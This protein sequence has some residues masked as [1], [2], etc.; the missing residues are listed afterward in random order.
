MIES[1]LVCLSC[2]RKYEFALIGKCA[3][4]RMLFVDYDLDAV[5]RAWADADWGGRPATMWRYRELLPVRHCDRVVTLD[6]GWTE[7]TGWRKSLPDLAVGRIRIK[8]EENNPTGSFKARGL[9]CAVSLLNEREVPRAVLASNGNAATALAAYAAAAGIKAAVFMP[10]DCPPSNLRICREYGAEIRIVRGWIQDAAAEAEQFGKERGYFNLGTLREPGRIEG[11]KTMGFEIA[12][13]SQWR[14]PTAIVYPTG[15]GS[16][17]I[18]M[19]KAF[20]ELLEIGFAH[21]DMPRFYCVQAEGC[22]PVVQALTPSTPSPSS[23]LPDPATSHS[24][25]R[26]PFPPDGQLL[27]DIVRA[28]NGK[29][30]AVDERAAQA[31]ERVYRHAGIPASPEGAIGLAGLFKLYES[32]EFELRDDIILFNTAHGDLY[33]A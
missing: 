33:E 29:A 23:F 2:G 13:Q 24:G 6:E 1:S 15:G 4:G 25:V 5:R 17:L 19:W 3:C 18:G 21:G 32:G 26:V 7:L 8:R 28:T 10:A 30:V 11:K 27:A 20:R 9:S 22:D 14:L 16:G 12:E 31:A